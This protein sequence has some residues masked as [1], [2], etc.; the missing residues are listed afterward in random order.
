MAK[1]IKGPIKFIDYD[2]FSIRKSE[3][4]RHNRAA[5]ALQEELSRV[6]PSS[7]ENLSEPINITALVERELDKAQR[8][9]NQIIKDAQKRAN[10]IERKAQSQSDE[11]LSNAQSQADDIREKAEQ[12]V[13]KIKQ[14]AHRKAK[15]AGKEEGLKIGKEEGLKI[16]HQEGYQQG[17]QEG[18][19]SGE[20]EYRDAIN[21]LKQLADEISS[22]RES[23]FKK[24]ESDFIGLVFDIAEKIVGEKISHNEVIYNTL[25]SA[26]EYAI[27]SESILVKVN[28][29]DLDTL[30]KYREE[31][32]AIVGESTSLEIIE[33]EN[34]DKGGCILETNMGRIDAQISSQMNAIRD[35]LKVEK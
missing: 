1:V 33:D 15:E 5:R 12:D 16:G 3:Q 20:K 4:Q 17:Y 23:V 10:D 28:P 31:F 22:E 8:Q 26:L 24:T 35:K 2:L 14:E 6:G 13:Q 11:L 21:Y 30:G 27:S 34:V 19:S 29:E 32:L 25:K 9:A 7:I 18:L